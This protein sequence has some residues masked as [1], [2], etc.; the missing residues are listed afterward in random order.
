MPLNSV[1]TNALWTA[2]SRSWS[3]RPSADE[4]HYLIGLGAD[5]SAVDEF[6]R[7]MFEYAVGRGY[8][9]DVLSQLEPATTLPG[10]NVIATSALWS[11][12]S[13]S[14]SS[15]PSVDEVHYLIGLGADVS[16]VDE[17]GRSM[18][19]YA[20]SRGYARDLL[21]LLEPAARP[22]IPT[23]DPPP[24]S[25]PTPDQPT[26]T[27]E[28]GAGTLYYTAW[29]GFAGC[30]QQTS[31]P[32]FISS[33]AL[34]GYVKFSFQVPSVAS[35]SIGLFYHWVP[36]LPA[37]SATF[38]YVSAGGDMKVDHW[39]RVDSQVLDSVGP[40]I[41]APGVFDETAGATNEIAIWT[42]QFG[43]V[44]EV[45]GHVALSVP[46]TELRPTRGRMTICSG[47]LAEETEDYTIHYSGLNATTE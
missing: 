4:V 15:R 24:T 43:S 34:A 35:W 40:Y 22:P 21:Q 9:S 3:S 30:P 44:L 47:L 46:A 28:N 27:V 25:T 29:D 12:L 32:A 16:A 17:F 23:P 31:E 8:A 38:V 26:V 36:D 10:T 7:S 45:N 2:L 5:V 11:A 20:V 14:W 13:R 1:A 41:V 19:V 33:N 42:D 6:G 39:T 18:F 37:D